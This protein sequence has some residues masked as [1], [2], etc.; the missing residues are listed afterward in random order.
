MGTHLRWHRLPS[1]SSVY[2]QQRWRTVSLQGLSLSSQLPEA[3]LPLPSPD[4]EFPGS[5]R[6]CTPLSTTPCY[7]MCRAGVTAGTQK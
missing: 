7:A 5:D 6:G 3:G 4:D 2:K 1:Q